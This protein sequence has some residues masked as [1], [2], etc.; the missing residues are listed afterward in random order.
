MKKLLLLL[1]VLVFGITGMAFAE[2]VVLSVL[3]GEY[4]PGHWIYE[5]AQKDFT[6]K[7]GIQVKFDFVAW[8][9]YTDKILVT[10]SAHDSSYDIIIGDSQLLGAAVGGGHYVELTDWLKE[11]IAFDKL[12]PVPQKLY[13][14]YPAESGRFYG[15]S[16]VLD[17]PAI[18]YRKDL[19]EDP[20]EKEAFKA[21]YGYDLDIPKTWE[22]L[23]D[24]AEFFT[25]PEQNLYGL[26]YWP[27]KT[28]DAV[29]M[30]FQPVMWSFGADY[31]A[32]DSY[33]VEGYL[34]S[35][36]GVKALEFYVNL[37]K[38]APPG[39]E[40]YYWNECTQAISQGLVA[41]AFQWGSWCEG[42]V[43]P[44]TNP[45]YYD[46]IGFFPFPGKMAEDGT[47]R[48]F[49]THGGQGLNIVTYGKNRDAAY[50]FIKWWCSEETQKKYM[51]MGG[52]PIL[53]DLLNSPEFLNAK[54]YNK[55]MAE[56]FKVVKDFWTIPEYAALL[57]VTQKYWSAA[58]V[59]MM[60]PKEAMD[61]VAKEHTQILKD[62][63]YLK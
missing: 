11:N 26:A 24:I 54:T 4:T 59:G 3:S 43:N 45:Q 57:E 29:T 18:G 22:Q 62:A 16:G 38:F 63:G 42:F 52:V 51:E 39:S 17:V 56:S 46:K 8:A 23:R 37:M 31:H 47:F 50:E 13:G 10:L 9:Q 30:G 6:A 40:N 49:A 7:T 19:F 44:A 35:E 28:F 21:K 25:R 12:A 34:N 15:V 60:S 55:A 2:E 61:A 14:E 27:A 53:T 58:C 33:E 41:M 1:L 36:A 32:P 20:K 5:L 48:Q